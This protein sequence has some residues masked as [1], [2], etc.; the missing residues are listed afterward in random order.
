MTDK[1]AESPPTTVYPKPSAHLQIYV[2]ILG[3]DLT[4]KFIMKFGGA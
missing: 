4:I 2:D 1:T 3:V